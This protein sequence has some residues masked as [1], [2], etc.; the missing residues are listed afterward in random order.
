MVARYLAQ[1]EG[2]LE[3]FARKAFYPLISGS[4]FSYKEFLQ[5]LVDILF[6]SNMNHNGMVSLLEYRWP[7]KLLYEYGCPS[8]S[9]MV[10]VFVWDAARIVIVCNRFWVEHVLL[11]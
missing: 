9:L 6:Y 4:R 8:F 3:A 5:N 1:T 7:C 2:I 10:N 11:L